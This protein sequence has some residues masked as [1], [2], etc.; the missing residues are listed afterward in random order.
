MQQHGLFDLRL[1]NDSSTST[2]QKSLFA[3]DLNLFHCDMKDVPEW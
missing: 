2:L 1:M 3:R